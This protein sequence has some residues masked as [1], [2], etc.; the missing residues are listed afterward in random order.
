[1][2]QHVNVLVVCGT[3]VATSTVVASR[4]RDHL[5][6]RPDAGRF[7]V[8]QGKVADLLSGS[9]SADLIVATTDVPS[10]VGVPVVPAVPLL[11]GLGADAVYARIDAEIAALDTR[12]AGAR[13]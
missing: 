6:A 8:G 11:T 13:R 3:G 12:D 10:A 4:V 9:G 2:A 5:S 7:T 1:M